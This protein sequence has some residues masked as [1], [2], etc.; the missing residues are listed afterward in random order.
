MVKTTRKQ[1][2][3]IKRVYDCGSDS[4]LCLSY[5]ALR[6]LLQPTFGFFGH[7]VARRAVMVRLYFHGAAC[8]FASRRMVTVT[9]KTKC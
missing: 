7:E 5:R 3:A 9:L 4:N 2:E 1:R 8:G 6:K